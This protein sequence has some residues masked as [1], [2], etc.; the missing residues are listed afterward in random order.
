MSSAQLVVYSIDER[1]QRCLSHGQGDR[2]GKAF[3]VEC[4]LL[5][6]GK[7]T[8]KLGLQEWLKRDPRRY[9]AVPRLLCCCPVTAAEAMSARLKPCCCPA[10]STPS[11]L[12]FVINHN[13]TIFQFVMSSAPADQSPQ[14]TSVD[15]HLHGVCLHTAD[16]TPNTV[17]LYHLH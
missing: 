16:L 10:I 6:A 3:G 14:A 11:T 13:T 8:S 15:M 7:V 17:K 2:G 9:T 1:K 5:L 4:S 12:Q